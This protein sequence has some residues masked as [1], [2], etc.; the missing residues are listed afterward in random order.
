M[1]LPYVELGSEVK[2]SGTSIE[3]V[4]QSEGRKQPTSAKPD[5]DASRMHVG[6]TEHSRPH[7]RAVMHIADAIYSCS[8]YARASLHE[9]WQS[10]YHYLS[11]KEGVSHSF[12]ALQ[13][14]QV[15]LNLCWT[16]LSEARSLSS[17][18]SLKA[19]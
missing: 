6:G 19:E 5:Q 13:V 11:I 16:Q 10:V 18:H 17:L 2:M 7:M 12:D 4:A 1:L 3:G 8:S 14:R 15:V 9:C